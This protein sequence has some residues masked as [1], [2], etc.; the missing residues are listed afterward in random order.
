MPHFQNTQHAPTGEY[1]NVYATYEPK[2]VKNVTRITVYIWW[3]KANEAVAETGLM[4]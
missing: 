2:Y 3:H 1:A 4:Y